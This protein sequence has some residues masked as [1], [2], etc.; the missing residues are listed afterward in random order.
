[1]SRALKIT[2]ISIA[3]IVGLLFGGFKYMQ[4]QT[5]KASPEAVASG[6]FGDATVSVNYCQPS[7]KDRTIFGELV[8]YGEVWRT[9]ANE[10]TTFT[11]SSDLMIQGQT[12]PAGTY[13]LWTIPGESEWQV[14]WNSGEYSWGVSWGGV[15]SR[16]ADKDVLTVTVPVSPQNPALEMFTIG[17]GASD[18]SMSWDD[19][20]VSVPMGS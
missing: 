17:F 10:A 6:A 18:M 11:T 2:F 7:V 1:M 20:S 5:K 8:P 19:I 12:L 13:T 14:I 16:E 15:A 3:V 4:S 9:G